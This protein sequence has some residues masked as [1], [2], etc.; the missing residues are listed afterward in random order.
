MSAGGQRP[1]VRAESCEYCSPLE[2]IFNFPFEVEHIARRHERNA[3]S[4]LKLTGQVRGPLRC[5]LQ[6]GRDKSL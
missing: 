6:L 3:D 2:V 1:A 4:W 5:G